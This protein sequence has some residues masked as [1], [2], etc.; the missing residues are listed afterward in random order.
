MTEEEAKTKYCPMGGRSVSIK[1]NGDFK[2]GEFTLCIASD[3]M[4]WEPYR[5]WLNEKGMYCDETATGAKLTEG[6]DC[7]L[8]SKECEGCRL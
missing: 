5:Y 3:C 7:G 4:M 6:G 2:V 1:S 8:K